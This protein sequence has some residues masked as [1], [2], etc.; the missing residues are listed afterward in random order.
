MGFF[1]AIKA[2]GMIL[3]VSV[4]FI[5]GLQSRLSEPIII[6]GDVYIRK[7][8]KGVYI[9]IGSSI[10]LTIILFLLFLKFSR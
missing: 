3:L 5:Y 9:P 10:A 7:G 2:L 6:P 1:D 8:T 4:A